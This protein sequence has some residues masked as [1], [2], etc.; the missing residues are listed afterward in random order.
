MY[1]VSAFARHCMMMLCTVSCVKEINYIVEYCK[2]KEFL[3]VP[4]GLAGQE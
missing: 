3:L 4:T 1:S 2:N